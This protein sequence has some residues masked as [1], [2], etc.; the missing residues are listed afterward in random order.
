MGSVKAASPV[1]VVVDA[2]EAYVATGSG[3]V[4]SLDALSGT[5]RWCVRYPRSGTKVNRGYSAQQANVKGWTED[6]IVVSGDQLVVLA[7][8]MDY[9]FSLNRADGGIAWES[10]RSP[11]GE[12]LAGSYVLGKAGGKMYVGGP[13][14]VR[15]YDIRGGR[16]LWQTELSES[17]YG[18]GTVAA[19]GIYI[20]INKTIARLGLEDGKIIKQAAFTSYLGADRQ[21]D[22]RREASVRIWPGARLRLWWIGAALQHADFT[23]YFRKH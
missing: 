2:G 17:S 18:K 4:F 11:F 16:L 21:P 15:C 13:R 3:V 1:K 6:D 8:D 10:A 12:S 19:D 14:V 5:V 23:D 22:R 7:C 20:P 9:V